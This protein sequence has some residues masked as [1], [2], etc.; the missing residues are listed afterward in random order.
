[1]ISEAFTT[2]LRS[3]PHVHDVDGACQWRIV[4]QKV[5]KRLSLID[6]NITATEWLEQF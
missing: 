2:T 3:D 5:W 4:I 1:M 6:P